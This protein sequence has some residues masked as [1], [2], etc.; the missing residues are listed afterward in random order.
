[1]PTNIGNDPARVNRN[2]LYPARIFRGLDPNSPTRR[3]IGIKTA[4]KKCKKQ[5][6]HVK[7]DN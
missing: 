3:N 7:Y 2:I 5:V 6:D 4:S 1:M